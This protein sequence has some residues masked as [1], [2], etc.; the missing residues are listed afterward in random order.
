LEKAYRKAGRV[1]DAVASY[2]RAL[3]L[4]PDYPEAHNNLGAALSTQRRREE[5]M[6]A[7]RRAIELRPNYAQAHGNLGIALR[8]E[9]HLEEALASYRRAIEYN[10]DDAMTH[11]NL[12]A[13]LSEQGRPDEAAA[14]CLRALQIDPDS[15]AALNNLGSVRRDQGRLD[16]AVAAFRRALQLQPDCAG[17]HVNLG[18][19]LKDRGVLDA[20]I[21][22]YRR[23]LQLEPDNARLH[24]N[25]VYTLHFDP[26]HDERSIAEEH[27]RWSRQFAD[28]LKPFLL[29]HP[30]DSNPERRLRVGYVSPD[31]CGHVISHFLAPLL[32]AHDRTEFEIHCYA[33]VKCPDSMTQ[34][35]KRSADVWRDVLGVD[36][37]A[38]AQQIREDRIDILV[39]LTQHM[40][41]NRLPVFARK[42]APVQVAWLGYPGSTGLEAIDFRL[43][44]ATIEPEGSAWS[45]SVEEPVRL[46]DSWFCFAPLED[47]PVPGELPALRSG[48]VTFGCMNNFCKSNE[49][50]FT[51]WSKVLAATP[52]SKLLLVC[53]GGESADRIRQ[54]FH[55][56]GIGP[57]RLELAAPRPFQQYLGLYQQIDIGLDPFPYTGGTT[58]CDA[59]WMGVPVVSLPG[60][61][62]VSRIG[63]SILTTVG[64]PELAAHSE[65]EYVRIATTLAVDLPRLA[66]LR[67]T[68]RD[69][70]QS[71]RL[72]D[73][74]RFAGNFEQACR[75]MWRAWCTNQS[76]REPS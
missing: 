29:P 65:D 11:S 1:D 69:R 13:V 51:V 36:D 60:K 27:R 74:P 17:A 59:L 72:M 37:H 39:D 58:T 9:G 28:P 45:Q 18:N 61:R 7:Y 49:A 63:L 67:A 57:E 50:V 4:K 30:N 10:P 40:A 70:M 19:A 34:R 5:A 2:R 6:A 44:D 71:S 52:D 23:A 15:I 64:L 54:F 75:K 68:L 76:S 38:L 33:S 22:A 53:P 12:G 32:E 3:Q 25:L 55:S 48:S 46:P 42:P 24:S 43:T 62:A 31:F 56:R 66:T 8:E 73:A 14:A 35:V 26:D 21:A 16:D 47:Y 20:A 41:D